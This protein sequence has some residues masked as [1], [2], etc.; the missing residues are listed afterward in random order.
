VSGALENE[1][2]VGLNKVIH[3]VDPE[4]LGLLPAVTNVYQE[5]LRSAR[6]AAQLELRG[7]DRYIEIALR[8]A[9]SQH[10]GNKQSR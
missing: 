8:H 6:L 3:E 2:V 10:T 1:F 9:W 7:V 5:I 4:A